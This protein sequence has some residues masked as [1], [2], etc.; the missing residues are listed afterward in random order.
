L[1]VCPC[2]KFD[3]AVDDALVL[4]VPSVATIKISFI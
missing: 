4:F 3:M 1:D 2:S